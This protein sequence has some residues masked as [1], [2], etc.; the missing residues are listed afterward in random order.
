MPVRRIVIDDATVRRVPYIQGGPSLQAIANGLGNV[1]QV[2]SFAST[3]LHRA[4]NAI[5]SGL[6]HAGNLATEHLPRLAQ[7]APSYAFYAN[8]FEALRTNFWAGAD[9]TQYDSDHV[10]WKDQDHNPTVSQCLI[11]PTPPKKTPAPHPRTLGK[12]KRRQFLNPDPPSVRSLSNSPPTQK[13]QPKWWKLADSPYTPTQ[14][15]TQYSQ[16]RRRQQYASYLRTKGKFRAR[17]NY[18]RAKLLFARTPLQRKALRKSAQFN[19]R[20]Y[21]RLILLYKFWRR[22]Y[23]YHGPPS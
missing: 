9:D 1:P 10:V 16:F 18:T 23:R 14:T 19:S 7:S 12:R 6:V 4:N 13:S 20:R 17:R 2:A 11:Q 8:A 5:T 15:F 3:A 22:K 21:R